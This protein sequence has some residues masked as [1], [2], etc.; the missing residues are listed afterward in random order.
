MSKQSL[1]QTIYEKAV[2]IPL[3]PN[4]VSQQLYDS[5]L[6]NCIAPLGRKGYTYPH[7]CRQTRKLSEWFENTPRKLWNTASN[8]QG[9]QAFDACTESAFVKQCLLSQHFTYLSKNNSL[10]KNIKK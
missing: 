7:C 8:F 2:D 5:E 6:P 4:N 3:P 9:G 1:S 10:P